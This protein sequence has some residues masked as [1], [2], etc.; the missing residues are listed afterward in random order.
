MPSAQAVG[1]QQ[2]G[3]TSKPAKKLSGEDLVVIMFSLL[4]LLGSVGLWAIAA[5]TTLIS[6]SA[7]AGLT[8]IAY[9]F[10]GG[11]Q[12]TTFGTGAAKFGGALAG[13][14][15]IVFVLNPRLERDMRFRLVSEDMMLGEWH[16]GYGPGGWDGTLKFTKVN[17]VLQ[18]SGSQY[19]VAGQKTPKLIYELTKGKAHLIGMRELQLESDVVDHLYNRTFHWVS[20][21]SFALTPAFRGELRPTDTDLSHYTWGIAIYKWPVDG[22]H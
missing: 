2:P 12:G 17:G 15:G 3:E 9:R 16:W 7:A 22:N 19:L 13:I 11:V 4:F 14:I 8:A 20:T 5:P 1:H 18:F 10:L 21:A 6:I